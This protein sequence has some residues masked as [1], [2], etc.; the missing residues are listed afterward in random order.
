MDFEVQNAEQEDA[1][2]HFRK[3]AEPLPD[4]DQL[5]ATQLRPVEIHGCIH[6]SRVLQHHFRPLPRDVPAYPVSE[7]RVIGDYKRT[8]LHD[9]F[10]FMMI[11]FSVPVPLDVNL[12]GLE[13]LHAP[14]SL[15]VSLHSYNLCFANLVPETCNPR[16]INA[17]TGFA[18]APAEA[19]YGE[20][21]LSKKSCKKSR[22]E[23]NLMVNPAMLWQSARA[24]V[25]QF[26]GTGGL[27][28]DGR[29]FA[30]KNYDMRISATW[31]NPEAGR[32]KL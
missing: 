32:A 16:K 13:L 6:Y 22:L 9:D 24:A 3:A 18:A 28:S 10:V 25:R 31:H 21:R 1:S 15:D 29:I 14:I 4:D 2:R 5:V 11:F 7:C 17:V 23:Q 27:M 12:N 20:R 8:S 30:V 19:H 26:A